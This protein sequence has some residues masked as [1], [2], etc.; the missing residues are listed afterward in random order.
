[1]VRTS[2][3][4]DPGTVPTSWDYT[5]PTKDT[6]RLDL[7]RGYDQIIDGLE[8]RDSLVVY[9]E[10]SVYRVDYVGG[11]FVDNFVKV[12]GI[13][14]AMNRNC[15][16]TIDGYHAVFAGFDC[17]VHDGQQAR[18]VLDKVTRLWLY[19]NIDVSNAGLCFVMTAPFF[20]KVLFCFP[21]PGNSVCNKAVEWDWTTNTVGMR[22]LPSSYCGFAGPVDNGL[23]ATFD[24][25][26]ASFNSH[27]NSFDGG[28]I[29]P[30][31]ARC[32]VGGT[33]P[34]FYQ[35]DSSTSADGS[36]VQA[37]L[38]RRAL[39][40]DI[41]EQRKLVSEVRPRILGNAG[42]TV[43]VKVGSQDDPFAEPTWQTRT[44]TIGSTVSNSFLVDGRYIAI[45]FETGT[46]T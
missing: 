42:D 18:S 36:L 13:T 8:L 6:I 40:F 16:A 25:D 38:E 46:A 7:S 30:S 35:L 1:M 26:S 41:P 37:Y 2:Q 39:S 22:D 31:L 9:K 32:M 5:D 45:R 10:S 12:L 34:H 27:T 44:H 21:T 23:G 28:T 24:A 11:Q 43:I 29:V 3:G 33:G 17:I 20:N 15:I 4:A 14:G 19:Q